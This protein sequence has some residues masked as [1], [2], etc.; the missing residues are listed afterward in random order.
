MQPVVV[1]AKEVCYFVQHGAPHLFHHVV[2]RGAH[3]LNGVLIQDDAVRERAAVVT[4]AGRQGMALV[5]AE[6]H[7]ATRQAD[8]AEVVGSGAAAD[9]NFHVIDPFREF[10]R[11]RIQRSL[12]KPSK[13]NALHLSPRCR[14]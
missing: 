10:R 2:F 9:K 3:G 14:S 13:A 11:N 12:H 7:L 8:R 4:G 1:N 5:E 6:Q